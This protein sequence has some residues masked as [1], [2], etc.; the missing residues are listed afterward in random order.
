M[1][2]GPSA[3]RE[4]LKVAISHHR[5]GD[6]QKAREI[7]ATILQSEPRHPD[8]LQLFGLAAQQQGDYETAIS[9]IRL[10]VE[11][12]P[13]QP[14][15]R[16][17]LGDALRRAGDLEAATQQFH[18]ALKLNPDYAGAHQNLGSVYFE[19]CN[20]TA[21]LLH[22]REAVRLDQHRAEAWF[23]L[24]L[25]LLDHVL[26][27]ESVDAFRKA[28]TIRPQYLSA[29]VA[30]LYTLNLLPGAD[31]VRVAAEHSVVAAGLFGAAT[32]QRVE[33]H[34]HER[35]RV[36]YVSGEFCAHA[37]N[38]FFEPVLKHQN[39]KKF[40]TFCYSDTI[41][42]DEVTARLKGYAGHWREIVG[43][44]DE[45]VCEQVVSDE[46]DI[47]FDL[48]G[49][50]KH[51][52][53]GV[54]ARKPA[55]HQITYLGYPNTTG[56]DS[57]DYRI[58]DAVTAPNEEVAAGTETLL[59]LRNG[60]ACFQPPPHAPTVGS[61]P[62]LKNG[63]VTLG[64]LHKLEKVNQSVIEVWAEV[65]QRNP[66]SRLL[67]ARDELDDWHQ[68]RLRQLF[69]E[70]GVDPGRLV[71]THLTD[72]TKSFLELFSEIDILLDTFPWSGHTIGCMALWMGIPVVSLYGTSH[73]GRMVSSVLHQ[74]GLGDL[75]T[76]D[77]ESYVRKISSLCSDQDFLIEL[78][79]SLRQ[80]FE[81]APLRNEI[82][83]TEELELVCQ[84][85]HAAGNGPTA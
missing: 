16:N 37:V 49:Y 13:D 20:H 84:R 15:L 53:L 55:R 85:I 3:S 38:C 48:A 46:I 35:I 71:M 31:P 21:A 68:D 47:L 67:M 80:R 45:A 83:F 69:L 52:R 81:N 19:S 36:G 23:N 33:T 82:A 25:I 5:S 59:R 42:A 27:E 50:T 77:R 22:A 65:L 43:W 64:C 61:A 10:A 4:L 32:C 79:K 12:V 26:L 74:L 57:M 2:V 1:K 75:V 73:A 14:V 40:E 7:Y 70:Q 30:L 58:V 66:E 72:P 63:F 62:L 17:N 8:A 18:Y 34:Q 76:Q 9:Y 41:I 28:L 60:F 29:G 6:I 78:R 54:F 24:G 44:S 51:N 39:C 11:I 56:L